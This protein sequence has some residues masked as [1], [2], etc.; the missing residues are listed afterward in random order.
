MG[1][2][3]GPPRL[4][5]DDTKSSRH[6]RL[7][8]GQDE[9]TR[10]LD[11]IKHHQPAQGEAGLAA[12]NP[13]RLTAPRSRF[14]DVPLLAISLCKRGTCGGSIPPVS[15]WQMA[16]Q[17]T[18]RERLTGRGQNLF[19]QGNL[20]R[21]PWLCGKR[22]TAEPNTAFRQWRKRTQ[23][24]KA[25]FNLSKLQGKRSRSFRDCPVLLR[26]H[27]RPSSRNRPFPGLR[28]RRTLQTT[29]N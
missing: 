4:L 3:Y 12:R 11:S 29:N 14:G 16:N 25:S 9:T 19:F 13:H 22:A 26:G 6:R 23:G 7:T 21:V 1:Y 8:N 17:D 2:Y 15:R 24:G 28:L 20:H 5:T 27:H 10:Q 18:E